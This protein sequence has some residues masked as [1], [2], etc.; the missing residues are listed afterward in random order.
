[1]IEFIHK[2]TLFIHIIFGSIA[3][4]LFWLPIGLKKG[5]PWHKKMG[6]YYYY[7]M[8]GV[9]GTSA[10]LSTSNLIQG[11]YMSAMYLGY[12]AIITSYPLWYSYDILRQKKE[13]SDRYVIIRKCFL[14]LM[15]LTAVGMVFLGAIIFRFEGMGMMMFFFGLVALP[16]IR[17]LLWSKEKAMNKETRMK[18]HIQG[19]I[20]TGIAAYTAFFAFGGSRILM[21]VLHMNQKWMIVPWVLP[22]FLGLTYAW[23]MKRKYLRV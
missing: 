18:M 22:T 7:S 12:L 2:S 21:E 14:T 10:I 8:W 19:T 1:M 4:I 13:W 9:L 6:W 5:S 20:I 17:E 3:L 16:S 15:S 23:Y 11:N